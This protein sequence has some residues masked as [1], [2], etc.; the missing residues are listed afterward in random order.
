MIDKGYYYHYKHDDKMGLGHYAYEV[1]GL[2]IGTENHEVSVIYRPL[3]KNEDMLG[4]DFY[5]RP[6][7]MFKEKIFL[8]EVQV[9]RFKIIIDKSTIDALNN[10][11][12][13]MYGA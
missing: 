4:H 13:E 10:I 7:I 2:G 11:R 12:V 8:D 9:D 3:Y 5:L 6:E 1:I